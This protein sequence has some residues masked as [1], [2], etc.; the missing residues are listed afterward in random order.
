MYVR[1]VLA[2]A[3]IGLFVLGMAWIRDLHWEGLIA[4][5]VGGSLWWTALHLSRA[6]WYAAREAGTGPK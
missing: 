6:A 4:L 3:A 1:R 2:A 5:F